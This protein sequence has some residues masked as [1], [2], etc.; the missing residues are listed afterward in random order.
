MAEYR[1]QIGLLVHLITNQ[2]ASGVT[3]AM[4]GGVSAAFMCR[5]LC[6]CSTGFSDVVL[7]HDGHASI[8]P[9]NTETGPRAQTV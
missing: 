2:A 7:H 9:A 4:H 3:G 8:A 5:S 6:R 1:S